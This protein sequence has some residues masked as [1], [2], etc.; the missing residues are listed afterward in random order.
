MQSVAGIQQRVAA[1]VRDGAGRHE[2]G[3]ERRVRVSGHEPVTHLKVNAAL[4][5][6]VKGVQQLLLGT[7]DSA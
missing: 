3:A 7:G 2:A 5:L 1:A 4:R 6:A